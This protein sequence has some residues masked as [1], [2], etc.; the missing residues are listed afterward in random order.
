[1]GALAPGAAVAVGLGGLGEILGAALALLVPL[2]ER[3]A[4]V[5]AAQLLVAGALE[6][7]A[8]AHRIRRAAEAPRDH[9]AD[10][11]AGERGADVTAL[12]V[13][14]ERL[15]VVDLGADAARVDVAP[16]QADVARGEIAGPAAL[17]EGLVGVVELAGVNELVR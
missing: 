13:S 1:A 17:G 2:A 10:R 3:L 5:P 11:V 9:A 8:R 12:R 16:G 6:V 4:G 14:R 15:L 7:A